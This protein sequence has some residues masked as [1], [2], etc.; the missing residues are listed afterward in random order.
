MRK[1]CIAASK[2]YIY[3]RIWCCI[4]LILLCIA[5]QDESKASEERDFGPETYGLYA[6]RDAGLLDQNA[7]IRGANTEEE[8]FA[9]SIK[10]KLSLPIDLFA[11]RIVESDVLNAMAAIIDGERIIVASAGFLDLAKVRRGNWTALGILAHEIGH[12][13]AGHTLAATSEKKSFEYELEADELAGFY[14]ALM[15]AS[16]NDAKS[17]VEEFAG[18][19]Q[20]SHPSREDRVPRV[21]KGWD[22]ALLTSKEALKMNKC[23]ELFSTAGFLEENATLEY[24]TNPEEYIEWASVPSKIGTDVLRHFLDLGMPVDVTDEDGN[25][26]LHK[27]FSFRCSDFSAK[28]EILLSHG[29]DRFKENK[30]GISPIGIAWNHSCYVDSHFDKNRSKNVAIAMLRGDKSDPARSFDQ[31]AL[32]ETAKSGSTQEL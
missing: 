14:M 24:C 8:N 19:N 12:H 28:S 17:A 3:Q 9:K 2:S 1:P 18:T 22:N 7:S 13:A 4:V 5:Y 20:T 31:W 15:G 26:A 32:A 27:I 10:M 29:A 11:L 23:R 16:K 30:D 21:L 6:F 25:T